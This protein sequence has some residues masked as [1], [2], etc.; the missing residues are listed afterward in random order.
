MT[1][2]SKLIFRN[3]ISDK[4]VCTYCKLILRD[5]VQTFC[6]HRYC[7]GCVE[8]ILSKPGN[9]GCQACSDEHDENY[10]I[11]S[12]EIFRDRAIKREL[13][14]MYVECYNDK[15]MWKGNFADYEKHHMNECPQYPVKCQHCGLADFLREE[16]KQHQDPTNGDCEVKIIP[17]TYN[18]I[19]C[20]AMIP[21]E[22]MNAHLETELPDHQQYLLK[23][24][25]NTNALV[26]NTR[27][28]KKVVQ[29]LLE[30]CETQVEK[31]E[32]IEKSCSKIETDIPQILQNAYRGCSARGEF[33][34]EQIKQKDRMI[35]EINNK[36][37]TLSTEF[38]ANEANITVLN[39]Q[40]ETDAH[41][42]QAMER[43]RIKTR[44]R[45]ESL[46]R[47]IK[48]QDRIIALKD[49]TLA[50]QDLR[51]QSL[52]MASY[53]GVLVWKIS[54]FNRKRNAAISGLT[55]SIYSPCFFTSRQGYKMCARIYL[56]GDG[57]GKGNHERMRSPSLPS[58]KG[59]QDYA[60]CSKIAQGFLLCGAFNYISIPFNPARQDEGQGMEITLIR[61]KTR[62]H[63][64]SQLSDCFC[65]LATISILKDEFFNKAGNLASGYTRKKIR[66]TDEII[67]LKNGW[68]CPAK[69]I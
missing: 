65:L 67:G 13:S 44:G 16:L 33:D 60:E 52:E 21:A 40:I 3:P 20:E 46:E 49:V 57:M 41:V 11:S 53:D 9:H 51:I 7:N 64:I 1:G 45:I 54:D 56:N 39:G 12:E 47:K 62:Y 22:C 59:K 28:N 30:K 68:L 32:E 19:G 61:N 55:T 36:L 14:T 35:V 8:D 37:T 26:K 69:L 25:L 48:S 10:V 58:F 15:C 66:N 34:K 31:I 50:E 42:V 43:E 24:Y 18:A 27:E 23:A 38:V 63:N 6:G 17:C 4:Y 2:Y 5:A 29:Q